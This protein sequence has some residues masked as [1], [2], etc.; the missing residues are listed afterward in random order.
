[1]IRKSALTPDL[2]FDETIKVGEDIDF[3]QRF[4]YR[5]EVRYITEPLAYYREYA[6]SDRL[7][8]QH[9]RYL[10]IGLKMISNFKAMGVG[11]KVSLRRIA[12]RLLE[13]E[14]RHYRQ[15]YPERE[16]PVPNWKR[17]LFPFR[18]L[19]QYFSGT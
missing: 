2:R 5:H 17:Q 16:S 6:Q 1:M 10:G 8:K 14:I 18:C 3:Y 15:A 13:M 9:A 4:F 19:K 11:N 12:D 7:S